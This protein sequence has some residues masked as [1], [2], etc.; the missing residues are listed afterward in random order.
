MPL[1][2][3]SLL[4]SSSPRAKTHNQTICGYC[5]CSYIA[6]SVRMNARIQRGGGKYLTNCNFWRLFFFLFFHITSKTPNNY[7]IGCYP[8]RSYISASIWMEKFRDLG[9]GKLGWFVSSL[10][11]SAEPPRTAQSLHPTN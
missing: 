10:L 4:C 1:I 2:T 11:Q 3:S 8:I 6:T 9:I 5:I 7:T